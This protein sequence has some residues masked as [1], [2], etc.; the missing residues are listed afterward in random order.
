MSEQ[1]L[2]FITDV[3]DVNDN[4]VPQPTV[5]A[6][7]K[8]STNKRTYTKINQQQLDTLKTIYIR[9]GANYPVSKYSEVTG[10]KGSRIR[11][12]ITLLKKGVTIDQSKIT[13]G[14]N[15]IIAPNAVS[16][17]AS[18]IKDNNRITLK[19]IRSNL[20]EMGITV[21]VSTIY[22]TLNYEW[23]MRDLKIS[24]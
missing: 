9:K 2:I 19:D 4:N 10:I 6:E 7:D 5:V 23:R 15:R 16:S 20:S 24:R 17:I 13:K 1:E 11:N 14:R 8:S 12:L 22:R 3:N 21:S 18:M